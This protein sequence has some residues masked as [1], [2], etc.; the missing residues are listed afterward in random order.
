MLLRKA[1]QVPQVAILTYRIN[2]LNG[3]L[4]EHAKDYHSRR[5]LLKMVGQR[6]NLLK[7]LKDAD[8]ERY[9]ALIARLGLR[10]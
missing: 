8:I 3:H 6:R 5:G 9:R 2:D 7:Y 1:T 10:K 4:K